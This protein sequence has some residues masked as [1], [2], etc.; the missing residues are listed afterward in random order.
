MTQ[1]TQRNSTTT[2]SS[3]VHVVCLVVFAAMPLS[4]SAPN[5]AKIHTQWLFLAKLADD[6]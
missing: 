6:R 5:I 1:N 4:S 3:A 2:A